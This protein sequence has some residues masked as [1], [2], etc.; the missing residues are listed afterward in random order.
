MIGIKKKIG[1]FPLT[2]WPVIFADFPLLTTTLILRIHLYL[3]MNSIIKE[4]ILK[5]Y[6]LFVKDKKSSFL[7]MRSH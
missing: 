1:E 5:K 6:F 2:F 4:N 7:S 3:T